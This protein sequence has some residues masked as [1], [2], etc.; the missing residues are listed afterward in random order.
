VSHLTPS[1][2]LSFASLPHDLCDDATCTTRRH[3][4]ASFE[5]KLEIPSPT[6]FPTKQAIRCRRVSSHH[7]HLLISFEAQTDKPPPTWFCDSN[8][9]IITVILR[10]KSPN[11]SCRFWGIN[12]KT[13]ASGFEAK[14]QEPLPPVLRPNQK[15]PSTYVLRLN[16]ETRAPCLIVYGADRTQ[17]YPTP[18]SSIHR[19]PD[20]CLTIHNPLHQ[21]S[22]SCLDPH[23]CPPCRTC[24]LHITR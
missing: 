11:R 22:Y 10:P 9:K 13:R 14:P 1:N 16:Q 21:V 18:R 5:A 20:L 23:H 6:C 24:H 19:V 3:S 7:L 4:S 8:Q 2:W 17:H 15:K 12:W